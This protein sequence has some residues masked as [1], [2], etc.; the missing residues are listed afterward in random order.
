[1]TATFMSLNAT[2]VVELIVF[3]IVLAVLA[4]FVVRPLQRAMRQ[5]Q[6]EIDEALE[7][8]R[9]VEELLARTE[10]E[11]EATLTRARREAQQI[12][13]TGRRIASHMEHERRESPR[14]WK[15]SSAAHG[16][17]A[18][19]LKSRALHPSNGGPFDADSDR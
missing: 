17:T 12:I 2:L 3:V 15:A 10:A 5:R 11:Y 4:R 1:M 16:R 13:E 19:A 7:K 9:R 18:M 14:P 8:A 6:I